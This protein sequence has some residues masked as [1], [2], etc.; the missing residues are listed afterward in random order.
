MSR[1]HIERSHELGIERAKSEIESIAQ[2]LQSE[3]GASYQ[4]EG[5]RLLLHRQGA[6]GTVEV[7]PDR[8]I[9]DIHLGLLLRPLK[10]SIERIISERLDGHLT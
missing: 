6:S 7:A 4:W 2:G 3:I 10:G 9:L 8:I 5:D 1:I